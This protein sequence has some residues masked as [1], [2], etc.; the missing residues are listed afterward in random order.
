MDNYSV[1][2]FITNVF[3]LI[4]TKL[5]FSQC[6]F[7]RFPFYIRGKRSLNGADNLT[8][9][10]FCRFELEGRDN[11]LYIGKDCQFG[12]L[13]HIVALKNV[14]IG[15]NVLVASKCFISDTNHGVY[16]GM[17]QDTP[18]TRPN[19]RRLVSDNVVIGDNVWIGENVVIL[20]G[21]VIGD[22]CIVGANSVVHGSFQENC[23]IAGVPAKVIKRFNEATGNW[24]KEE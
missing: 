5:F 12:D 2:E 13:T 4:R 20:A 9:G 15:N 7:I 8:L 10:R 22:G 17:V 21:T 1:S 23:I 11:T 6:R 3:S 24:E 18:Y 16:S 19:D 14:E